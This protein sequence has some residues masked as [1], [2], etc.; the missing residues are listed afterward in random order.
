MYY[1]ESNTFFEYSSRT[2]IHDTTL[3]LVIEEK[4]EEISF[5]RMTNAPKRQAMHR[6]HSI[7]TLQKTYDNEP[8]KDSQLELK[9][10]TNR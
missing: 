5:S 8:T 10:S 9:Q 3:K 7:E 6:R 2:E 4:R 1:F